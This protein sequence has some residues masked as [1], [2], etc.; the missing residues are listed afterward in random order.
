MLLTLLLFW[1]LGCVSYTE[2]PRL[3]LPEV[4][5][6]EKVVTY[7]GYSDIC[8]GQEV[9]AAGCTKD[10]AKVAFTVS[11]DSDLKLPRWVAYSLTKEETYGYARRGGKQFH[12]D[13]H[14]HIPQAE[15]Y[16]YKGSGWTKGHMAPAADFKWSDA[17]MDD[18]FNFTNVC[19][20]AEALNAG[21]WSK[22]ENRVR[23]W[24]RKF[25]EVYVVTGPVVGE[26]VN[27]TIGNNVTVPDAFFKALLVCSGGTF[28]SVAFIME[29][30]DADQPYTQ[31]S[32]TVNELESVIG[33]NLFCDLDKMV[34]KKGE[35]SVESQVDRHF[36]GI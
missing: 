21:G 15:Y 19:P 20:Q 3:E 29:N 25:G 1:V 2:V 6:D 24:A 33:V 9:T 10:P 36:W 14:A 17:A 23:S 27:G 5:A 22:L 31:C 26:A 34:G 16:D 8:Y 18:T 12:Q 35:E 28:Q 11:Y 7:S 32:V 4:R 13:T 30:S